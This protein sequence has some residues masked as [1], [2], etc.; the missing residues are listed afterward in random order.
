[1]AGGY[2]GN[3]QVKR[4]SGTEFLGE[5]VEWGQGMRRPLTEVVPAQKYAHQGMRRS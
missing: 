2:R 1:M 3:L 5:G 4:P